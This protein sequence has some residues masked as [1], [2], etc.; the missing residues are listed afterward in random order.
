MKAMASESVWKVVQG[1]LVCC[2][3]LQVRM[4][5]L[6]TQALTHER[7]EYVR[8]REGSHDAILSTRREKK[9]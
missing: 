2:L 1:L 5:L 8:G 3:S 7:F 6:Q 9:K 4:D